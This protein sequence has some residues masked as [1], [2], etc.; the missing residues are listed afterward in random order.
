MSP[1][2][3]RLAVLM[4]GVSEEHG[5]SVASGRAV[6]RNA[7]YGKYLLRPVVIGQEGRWYFSRRFLEQPENLNLLFW[8]G[9]DLGEAIV[10][11]QREI[12]LVF[13]V[14]HGPYGEDGRIQSLLEL[15]GIAY[16]CSGVLA[17]SIAMDKD[18]FRK[19]MLAENIIIPRGWTFTQKEWNKNRQLILRKAS[20]FPSWVLK[21]ASSGSS[22]GIFLGEGLSSLEEVVD[23]AFSIGE[24]LIIEER[25]WGKEVTCGV[26][27]G[28]K[29]PPQA[30][31]PVLIVPQKRDFFDFFSK[32]TPGATQEITPAPLVPALTQA[33][34][35]MALRI[36]QLLGCRGMSRVDFMVQE[37]SDTIYV[38]ELNT[39]P[40]LT[41]NSLIPKECRAQ[42]L[43][44]SQ[45]I[46]FLV[47][48]A[49]S[50]F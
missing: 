9:V 42:G 25:I 24:K 21:P 7:D 5:V 4:G 16:T 32:Y 39:I 30:L 45:L 2:K 13:I 6:I 10:R 37:K 17:S 47:T 36:H 40:G 20:L 35:K 19:I 14:L 33:I 15:A 1:S 27:G 3:L 43:S 31:P 22:F 34:Q 38:L 26:L 41:D 18:I 50:V 49:L 8:E 48:D 12:D 23:Q 28:G 44:F 11:L 46:D 29:E